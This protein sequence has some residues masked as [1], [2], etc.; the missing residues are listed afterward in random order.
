[1]TTSLHGGVVSEPLYRKYLVLSSGSIR[2]NVNG[3]MMTLASDELNGAK[4]RI[5]YFI[6]RRGYL[7]RSKQRFEKEVIVC[8]A[9]HAL[10]IVFY[11]CNAR[12]ETKVI[13]AAH[14]P[15]RILQKKER[16]CP[17]S[18]CNLPYMERVTKRRLKSV[19]PLKV[20]VDFQ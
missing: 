16:A 18:P 7:R 5:K 13:V 4:Q 3:S 20:W 15:I 2:S 11:A 8:I 6:N 14:L 12:R 17:H 19:A 1:M 9:L 10:Q